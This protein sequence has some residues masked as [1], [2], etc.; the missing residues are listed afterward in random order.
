MD[1]V[2]AILTLFILG[3]G[4]VYHLLAFAFVQKQKMLQEMGSE[5]QI[6]LRGFWNPGNGLPSRGDNRSEIAWWRFVIFF[7][8]K[9]CDF[10]QIKEGRF[11]GLRVVQFF[12][13]LFD[14][15]FWM[16]RDVSKQD[17]LERARKFL[18]QNGQ[19]EVDVVVVANGQNGILQLKKWYN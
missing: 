17:R 4:L 13:Q 14:R 12:R 7:E 9:F 16:F 5:E 8:E 2:Q 19:N 15:N 10:H 11:R 6:F 1:R 3:L 18:G